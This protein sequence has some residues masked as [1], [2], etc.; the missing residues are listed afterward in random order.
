MDESTLGIQ[1]AV[2]NEDEECKVA[3]SSWQLAV[4]SEQVGVSRKES[5][6]RAVSEASD[7]IDSLPDYPWPDGRREAME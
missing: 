1:A 5:V 7:P 3:L 6:R 2:N 4:S